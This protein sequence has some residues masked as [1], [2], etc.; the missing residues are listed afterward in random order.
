MPASA[1]IAPCRMNAA[2]ILSTST[3]RRA[4]VVYASK[5]RVKQ[6]AI[7]YEELADPKWR[8]FAIFLACIA[9]GVAAIAVA[10]R[11]QELAHPIAQR[12]FGETPSR[13]RAF[14]ARAAGRRLTTA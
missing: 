8:G 4:R 10:P 11:R 6:D 13:T 9:L 1:S 7:T 12:Q 2:A 14:S 5:D 3:A